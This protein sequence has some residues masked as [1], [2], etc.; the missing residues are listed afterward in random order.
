MSL[1][2]HSHIDFGP[3]AVNSPIARLIG[4][5]CASGARPRELTVHS[6]RGAK[7]HYLKQQA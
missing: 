7:R 1:C 2:A 4:P 3:N 6:V 5:I